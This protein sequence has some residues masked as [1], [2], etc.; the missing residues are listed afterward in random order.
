LV[1]LG[2]FWP[3]VEYKLM[4][5]LRLVDSAALIGPDSA[6]STLEEQEGTKPTFIGDTILTRLD[7]PKSEK[8]G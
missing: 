1:L 8:V 2:R 3:G 5:I 6:I 4:C 7:W